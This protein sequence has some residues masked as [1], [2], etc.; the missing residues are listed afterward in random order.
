[1]SEISPK[2]ES[3]KK[4]GDETFMKKDYPAAIKYYLGA[5]STF[6]QFDKAWNNMGLAYREIDNLNF[7][8]K[9]FKRAMQINED[10]DS[11]KANIEALEKEIQDNLFGVKRKKSVVQ[12]YGQARPPEESPQ[13]KKAAPPAEKSTKEDKTVHEE[14]TMLPFM[15]AHKEEK[16]EEEEVEKDTAPPPPPVEEEILEPP[17]EPIVEPVRRERIV[18]E[19]RTGPLGLRTISVAKTVPYEA[20]DMVVEEKTGDYVCSECGTSLDTEDTVCQSCAQKLENEIEAGDL[21]G[22]YEECE[23]ISD[24]LGLRVQALHEFSEVDED[25]RAIFKIYR[26][27]KFLSQADWEI[28]SGKFDKALRTFGAA[29]KMIETLSEKYLYPKAGKIYSSIRSKLLERDDYEEHLSLLAKPLFQAE[30]A[31]EK[32]RDSEAISFALRIKEYLDNME[33]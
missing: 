25:E 1:M 16:G 27:D 2:A 29:E 30:R 28:S 17:E 10:N 6:P 33:D 8:L 9:C 20:D 11:A 4:L 26:V 13:E 32:N 24:N 14:P 19:N 21:E 22:K 31:L 3:L 5:V 12:K 7:A 15:Q 23:E 18:I